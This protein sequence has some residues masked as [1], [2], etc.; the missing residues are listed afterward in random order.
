M[1]LK[2]YLM[3]VISS[4]LL[5]SCWGNVREYKYNEPPSSNHN[6]VTTGQEHINYNDEP[7]RV[8]HTLFQGK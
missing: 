8:T 6:K 7:N 3:L 5:T 1:K 4:I 2:F